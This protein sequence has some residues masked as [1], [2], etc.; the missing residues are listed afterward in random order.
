MD[1]EWTDHRGDLSL[2]DFFKLFLF[3]SLS[4]SKRKNED[5]TT[6][7]LRTPSRSL[8]LRLFP[9][10]TGSA[11]DLSFG[12]SKRVTDPLL[13]RIALSLII[14]GCLKNNSWLVSL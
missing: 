13:W 10:A 11:G 3:F 2:N 9:E 8:S 4:Y 12:V 1:R 6:L 5:D 7:Y 14:S